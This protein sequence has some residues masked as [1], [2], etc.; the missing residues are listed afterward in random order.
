MF[1]AF[2]SKAEMFFRKLD[3]D[4]ASLFETS[5]FYEKCSKLL[6]GIIDWN[7][8]GDCAKFCSDDLDCGEQQ[9]EMFKCVPAYAE[10][11]EEKTQT[12][13]CDC[14]E[15]GIIKRFFLTLNVSHILRRLNS[16]TSCSLIF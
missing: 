14:K 2:E 10:C 9:R 16:E 3:F 5:I 4:F 8:W 15:S 7:N 12:R 6:P 11:S 1:K 13:K